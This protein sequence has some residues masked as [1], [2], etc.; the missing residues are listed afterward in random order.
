M[1]IVSLSACDR[2]HVEAGHSTESIRTYSGIWLY[3][4]EGSTFLEG[5][6]EVPKAD[7]QVQNAP[8]LKF[9]PENVDPEYLHPGIEDASQDYDRYD[10]LR[11]C[12]PRF[13]FAISFEGQETKHPQL[14]P[15]L[16][17]AGHL[18]LWGSDLSIERVISIKPLIGD[19][20]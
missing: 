16:P 5:A 1:F 18:G 14:A 20:C 10:V 3:E 4:F 2:G 6:S 11:E 13:A 9:H 12:Y 7:V 17:G 19:F 8:W 15:N